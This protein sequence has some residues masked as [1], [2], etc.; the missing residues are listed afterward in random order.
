MPV[1]RDFYLADGVFRGRGCPLR[2]GAL[3]VTS[4]SGDDASFLGSSGLPGKA[5]FL[6]GI[7]LP[8]STALLAKFL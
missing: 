1:F 2:L 7:T 3:P 6:P 5:G 8:A 4:A